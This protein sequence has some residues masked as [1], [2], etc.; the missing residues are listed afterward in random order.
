MKY[1]IVNESIYNLN[2]ELV[3][4]VYKFEI[5]IPSRPM[6]CEIIPTQLHLQCNAQHIN[7]LIYQYTNIFTVL[8]DNKTTIEFIMQA[9]F[10]FTKYQDKTIYAQYILC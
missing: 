1:S 5:Q 6:I 4:P 7:Q 2:N 9:P 3:V 8:H 10:K